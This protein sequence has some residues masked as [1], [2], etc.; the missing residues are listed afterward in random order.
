ME[1]R[2][3]KKSTER[4]KSKKRKKKVEEKYKIKKNTKK[5]IQVFCISIIIFSPVFPKV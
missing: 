5:L 3:E 1:S 4:K 2:E